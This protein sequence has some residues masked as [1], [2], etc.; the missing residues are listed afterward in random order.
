MPVVEFR[1]VGIALRT[2]K[3][4]FDADHYVC[5]YSLLLLPLVLDFASNIY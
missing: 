4:G 2:S 3:G 1:T 5:K